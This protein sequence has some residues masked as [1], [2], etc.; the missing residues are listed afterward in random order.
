MLDTLP[1][2]LLPE[3][4]EVDTVLWA[5]HIEIDGRFVLYNSYMHYQARLSP[6]TL[7]LI[8]RLPHL[9]SALARMTSTSFDY[10]GRGTILPAGHTHRRAKP[11]C[12]PRQLELSRV[13][14]FLASQLAG[15]SVRP[16]RWA[17]LGIDTHLRHVLSLF[18]LD[19]ETLSTACP[20]SPA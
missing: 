10:N 16:T 2:L 1:S 3:Q 17:S 9:A 11:M 19:N 8:P 12:A 7:S 15:L 6:T 5:I 13:D 18:G 20:A 4:P 14:S